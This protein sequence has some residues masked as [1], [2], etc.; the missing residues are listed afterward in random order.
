MAASGFRLRTLCG[1][2]GNGFGNS[3][4][5]S[6]NVR[7]CRDRFASDHRSPGPPTPR[8]LSG[9]LGSR[10]MLQVLAVRPN[11]R[12]PLSATCALAQPAPWERSAPDSLSRSPGICGWPTRV[13]VQREESAVLGYSGKTGGTDGGLLKLV[14]TVLPRGPFPNGSSS[15]M[16]TV[17]TDR[18]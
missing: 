1:P 18:A 16:P 13:P 5:G 14:R 15:G 9:L 4:A 7:H 2:H 17:D 12:Q 3:R 10:S 6:I 8:L 11:P